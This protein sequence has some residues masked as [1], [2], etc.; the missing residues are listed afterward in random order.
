MSQPA[1]LRSYLYVPGTRPELAEKAY[2]SEADAVVLDLEDAVALDRKAE[3]RAA[4]AELLAAGPPKPT[5]VRLNAATSEYLEADLDALAYPSLAGV[6][7]PKVESAVQVSAVAA[8]LERARSQARIQCL[9]ESALGVERAFEIASA[10]PAVA[11]IGL[12]EADLAADLGTWGADGLLYARSRCVV[13]ARAAG[14][15]PPLQSVFTNVSDEEALRASCVEG[16]RYGFFGRSAIHPRQAIIINEV[17]SPS[18]AEVGEA[19]DLIDRLREAEEG[20]TGAF[21]LPDGGFVDRAVVES[22]QRTVA[23]AERL[24][25]GVSP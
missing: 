13:A 5:W 10:A 20:G 11:G 9:L 15:A 24:G 6:R 18:E 4:V 21:A 2:A 3:A 7:L 14:L 19:R 25:A 1:P 23:L 22:A 17:F 8:R 12:G 16:R